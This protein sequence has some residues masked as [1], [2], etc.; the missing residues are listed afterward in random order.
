MFFSFCIGTISSNL[1]SSFRVLI[2]QPVILRI[3][4]VVNVFL[5]PSVDD[6]GYDIADGKT[7]ILAS[8]ADILVKQI[9]ADD[10]YL[11]ANHP[12]PGLKFDMIGDYTLTSGDHIGS[13][14]NDVLLVEYGEYMHFQLGYRVSAGSWPNFYSQLSGENSMHTPHDLRIQDRNL[15]IIVKQTITDQDNLI[16]GTNYSGMCDGPICESIYYPIS[17]GSI[18]FDDTR[19]SLTN[20]I[21]VT[22]EIFM[23]ATNEG[24]YA[25]THRFVN[26]FAS[27]TPEPATMLLLGTGL[28]GI[29]GAARRKKK[30]NQA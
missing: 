22:N 21:F 11:N 27:P 29:A 4:P 30:K 5:T 18:Q 14:V 13:L 6:S 7:K 1:I 23:W 26:T 8:P 9:G 28:V 3:S 10:Y 2:L 25:Y 15:G 17:H 16:L 19:F 12:G 24:E 20:E